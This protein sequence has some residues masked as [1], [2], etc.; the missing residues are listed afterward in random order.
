M[1]AP[2]WSAS[3]SST[4]RTGGS[5]S[6][7]GSRTRGQISARWIEP[8]SWRPESMKRVGEHL[9][10]EPGSYYDGL[11]VPRPEYAIDGPGSM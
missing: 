3:T 4:S 5:G 7:W 2:G 11:E 8:S 1:M 6:G 10:L 9:D